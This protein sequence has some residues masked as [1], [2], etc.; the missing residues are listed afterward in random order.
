LPAFFCPN[1]LQ[2]AFI[3]DVWTKTTDGYALSVRYASGAN[4]AAQTQPENPAK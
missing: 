4:A 2:H 1:R 3:V